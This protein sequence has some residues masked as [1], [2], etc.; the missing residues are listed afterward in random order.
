MIQHLIEQNTHLYSQ[1]YLIDS[2]R[3]TESHNCLVVSQYFGVSRP[4]DPEYRR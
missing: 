4:L 1:D 3:S 2:V